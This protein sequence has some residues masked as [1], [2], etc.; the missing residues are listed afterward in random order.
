MA[1]E[2]PISRLFHPVLLSIGILL[3]ASP[4]EGADPPQRVSRTPKLR[5]NV[6]VWWMGIGSVNQDKGTYEADV[7]IRFSTRNT[8]EAYPEVPPGTA[9]TALAPH[10]GK[11]I[12]NLFSSP[13]IWSTEKVSNVLQDTVSAYRVKGLFFYHTSMSDFPYNS[14]DIRV[15]IEDPGEDIDGIEFFPAGAE[16]IWDSISGYYV[17]STEIE[18]LTR[19]VDGRTFSRVRAIAKLRRHRMSM[20]V[21]YIF[22]PILM[23]FV[24]YSSILL[25][26]DNI[27]TRF[28]VAGGTL[29]ASVLYHAGALSNIPPNDFV[30][31]LDLEMTVIYAL[32]SF[33]FLS[34]TI[35]SILVT[36]D[37]SRA[38]TGL[39]RKIDRILLPFWTPSLWVLLPLRWWGLVPVTVWLFVILVYLFMSDRFKAGG[40]AAVAP[41][42]RDEE[43][44]AKEAPAPCPPPEDVFLIKFTYDEAQKKGKATL[45]VDGAEVRK[46]VA[47]NKDEGAT[48]VEE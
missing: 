45:V 40:E 15:N 28:N 14:E 13:T 36:K 48:D 27:M 37:M 42:G 31:L 30:T 39:V 24:Q 44:P 47:P 8:T 18:A 9:A 29:V 4:S 10:V 2:R 5:V 17:E 7:I 11:V 3:L 43:V 12:S 46:A 6:S 32:T 25:T 35:L 23:W 1:R 19:T 22:P 34:S 16:C 38:Q 33:N 20:T 41:V 21:Q 26:L